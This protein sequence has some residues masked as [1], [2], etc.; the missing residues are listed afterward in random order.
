[1]ASLSA[2]DKRFLE[3]LFQMSEGY[4]L[5]FTNDRF[6][7]F[8]RDCLDIDIYDER[9]NRLGNSKAKR[10]RTFWNVADDDSVGRSI[11]DLLGHI[12]TQIV[13][14]ELK[15]EDFKPTLVAQCRAIGE[16]LVKSSTSRPTNPEEHATV[17][18]FLKT[19]FQDVNA[20]I[21][22]LEADIQGVIKQRLV[23]IEAT[24]VTA[25]LASIMLCGSTLEG[26]LLD[27]AKRDAKAF[28]A[29]K[30]APRTSGK[31][32]NLNEWKLNDLINVAYELGYVTKNVKD[33]GHALREFRNFIHPRAQVAAAFKP[34]ANTAKICFQVLKAALTAVGAKAVSVANGPAA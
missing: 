27:I 33:F 4:V 12:D 23:E 32:R 2:N 25:P 28:T 14:D 34:D 3:K 5:N 16:R 19:D 24:L 17:E 29:A 30:A 6:Q 13:L 11:L 9:Y 8:F 31:I 21:S 10:L 26:I 15:P 1:M 20:A 7:E 18:S 22:D